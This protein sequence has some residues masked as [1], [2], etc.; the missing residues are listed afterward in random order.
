MRHGL[1][2]QGSSNGGWRTANDTVDGRNPAS[3]WMVES[4]KIMG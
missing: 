2:G 1:I 3:P 4:L